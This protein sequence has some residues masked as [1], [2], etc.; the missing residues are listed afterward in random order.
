MYDRRK[1]QVVIAPV[2]AVTLAAWGLVKSVGR[3][4]KYEQDDLITLGVG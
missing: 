1:S 3:P 4:S 2:E